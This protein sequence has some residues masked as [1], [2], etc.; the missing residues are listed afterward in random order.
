MTGDAVAQLERAARDV[1]TEF[2]APNV[3]GGV[4]EPVRRYLTSAIDPGT[5]LA[6]GARLEMHGHIKLRAWLPFRARQVLVPRRGTVWSARVGG[7]IF[8]SDRYVNG[9]GGMLWRLFNRIP[10][11][12]AS[13]PDV[14]RSAAERA[15]GEAIWVPTALHPRAGVRWH[16]LDHCR[17]TAEFDVDER[18]PIAL[19]LHVDEAGYPTSVVFDRWGDPDNTGTWRSCPF[20][21]EFTR[22]DTVDGGVTIPVAGRAGWD[23]GT[24]RWPAGEFFRYEITRYELLHR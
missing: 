7:V 4:G 2:F 17:I 16:A 15:G 10:V 9:A 13:G 18:Y 23:Y 11:M 14:T 1:S 6:A 12:R 24:E 21:V 20:G 3:L 8:G 19:H 5:E 22:I